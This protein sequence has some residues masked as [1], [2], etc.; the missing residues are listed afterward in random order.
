MIWLCILSICGPHRKYLL[1]YCVCI[2]SFYILHPQP[3]KMYVDKTQSA[4]PVSQPTHYAIIYTRITVHLLQYNKCQWEITVIITLK[5]EVTWQNV[6]PA[7]FSSQHQIISFC[8]LCSIFFNNAFN[9]FCFFLF[10]QFC[11]YW[12]Q[13]ATY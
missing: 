2:C 10:F 4:S 1:Y 11:V 12:Y 5:C 7:L 6:H 8:I 9:L 3:Y 13:W